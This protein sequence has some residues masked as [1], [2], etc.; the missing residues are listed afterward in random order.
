[1]HFIF[2]NRYIK[3]I[4]LAAAIVFSIAAFLSIRECQKINNSKNLSVEK[5][6]FKA[7]P[8]DASA[9]FFFDNLASAKKIVIDLNPLS[10]NLFCTNTIFKNLSETL[11]FHIKNSNNY[12][13]SNLKSILS[14]HYSSNNRVS[15][16]FIL[17]ST[18]IKD[19]NEQ[20]SIK[21]S[22]N[23]KDIARKYNGIDIYNIDG[24]EIVLWNGYIITSPASI[25]VEASIRH[26]KSNSSILNNKAFENILDETYESRARLFINHAQIGKI[27]SG[28][29]DRTSLK[30]A[31]F[32][33]RFSSWSSFY[34]ESEREF[35]KI[36]GRPHNI[37]GSLYYSQIFEENQPIKSEIFDILPYNTFTLT[38]FTV[39]NFS[40]LTENSIKFRE[41]SNKNTKIDKESLEW[42]QKLKIKSISHALIPYGSDLH[43]LTIVSLNRS[44]FDN[45]LQLFKKS[46]NT[47]ISRLEFYPSFSNLYGDLFKTSNKMYFIQD[48]D[49]ILISDSLLLDEYINGSFSRF[50]LKDYISQ[51]KMN[52][53]LNNSDN[54]LTSYVNGSFLSDS[55]LRFFRKDIREELSRFVNK[56]NIF[57][58]SFELSQSKEGPLLKLSLYIDSLEQLPIAKVSDTLKPIGWE[59]D[60]VVVLPKGPFKL[61]NFNTGE[62]EYLEQLPS[63]WLRLLDKNKKGLWAIPFKEHVR[64][65]VEQIDYFDNGK[66]QMLFAS[67]DEIFLLDRAGRFVHGFPKEISD[68]I[69]LGPKL[70][71]MGNDNYFMLLHRGN[72]LRLYNSNFTKSLNW[73]DIILEETIKDFPELLSINSNIYFIL[74]TSLRTAI[75]NR[76]GV[77][78]GDFKGKMRLKPDTEISLQ[79][80]GVIFVKT[81]SNS[82]VLLNLETGKYKKV[83]IK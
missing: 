82:G 81:I 49:K 33:F 8:S 31:D 26:L 40:R 29:G 38:S 27:F 52:R 9:L 7:V 20:E 14:F 4:L 57:L 51:T 72:F 78:I 65:Y 39:N 69:I 41:F 60:T 70:Y 3:I 80:D 68:S 13:N 53:L 56:N 74:R 59:S 73:T 23:L 32:F 22:L 42:I 35:L 79:Q 46:Y 77:E 76:N 50:S 66:L 71:E 28:I 48:Y 12:S 54:Y 2:K 11:L 15:P 67:S 25:L 10:V 5:D 45:F 19:L 43:P 75:F 24:V 18:R 44:R 61:I 1:M 64:G 47:E 63:K 37:L 62:A 30:Y 16:L 6:V 36:V 21:R 58:S 83:K 34:I 17:Y 55:I